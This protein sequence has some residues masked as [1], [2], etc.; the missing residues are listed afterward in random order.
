MRKL[1]H[2]MESV[3]EHKPVLLTEVLE[4]LEIREDGL[5]VDGT[6]GGG[7]HSEEI[8]KRL[9]ENGK[10][11]CIDRDPD[12]LQA[13]G[14]RLER[15][16]EKVVLIRGNYSDVKEALRSRTDRDADGILLDLGVSSFQLDTPL[17]GFTYRDEEAPLDM[18]MDPSQ[19]LT[20]EEVVNTY[21]FEELRDILRDYGEERFAPSIAREIV[22]AREEAPIRTAGQL[23]EL[24]REAMPE[25]ELRKKGHPAKQAFQALRIEVNGELDGL[26]RF[27]DDVMD[28]LAP[29]GKLLIITFHSLEDR[30]VKKKMKEWENPCTCPKSFPVCVCGK[31][32]LGKMRPSKP[33]IAGNEELSL[34]LRSKSAKLRVFKKECT[35]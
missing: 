25:K 35:A 32:S 3:F 2:S 17:R 23:V 10:L 14:K 24:I 15:F 33:I 12:A 8:A 13:A 5:Y 27:L 19:S 16:G 11:Y 26:E 22:K 31:K 7:G 34:N 28:I 29:G 4:N 6:L 9:G 21:S 30:I 1:W 18:R 20:A